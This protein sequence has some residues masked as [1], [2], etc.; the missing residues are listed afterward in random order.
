MAAE[1]ASP[2]LAELVRF[3]LEA[4]EPG[5]PAAEQMAA[6]LHLSHPYGRPVVGWAEEI[7]HIDR[8]SAADFYRHHY[9]PNNA[10]LI[11]AGD[12]TPDEVR[13]AYCALKGM[14]LRTEVYAADGSPRAPNPYSVTEQNF[15]TS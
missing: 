10:V 2:S 15:C 5:N 4:N 3:L 11:V 14:V 6:A 12:V 1:L 8:A 7:R 9:A 13:E